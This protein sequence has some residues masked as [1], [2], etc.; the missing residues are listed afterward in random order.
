MSAIE[1][2]LKRRQVIGQLRAK[3][4]EVTSSKKREVLRALAKKIEDRH[5]LSLSTS[6]WVNRAEE[7]L[8]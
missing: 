5:H 2:A 4:R 7:M 6:W 8:K 3:A 1:D